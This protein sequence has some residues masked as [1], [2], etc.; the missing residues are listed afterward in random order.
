MTSQVQS[1]NI[2]GAVVAVLIN[3]LMISLFLF[4]LKNIP[5]IEYWIG[6]L[7]ILNIIPLGYLFIKSFKENRPI[8]YFIQIGLMISYLILELLLDYILQIDF[9]Q[10]LKIV[11]PYIVLFFTATGGMLGVARLAGKGWMWAASISFLLMTVLSF[12]QRHVT[13]Q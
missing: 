6:I 5:K 13:G 10:N 3:L 11:I 12:F 7:A 4:R 1:S 2:I 9:R 8:I